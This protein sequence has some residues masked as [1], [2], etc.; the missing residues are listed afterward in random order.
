[1]SVRSKIMLAV[2][3]ITAALFSGSAR[4][5]LKVAANAVENDAL[6]CAS[7]GCGSTCG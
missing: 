3:V 7:G 1:M 5:L 2:L 4:K 6:A